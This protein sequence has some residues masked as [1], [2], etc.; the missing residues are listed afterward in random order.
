MPALPR[1]SQNPPQN[2]PLYST[3]RQAH[4]SR[5][6][7]LLQRVPDYI[8][9]DAVRIINAALALCWKRGRAPEHAAE[10]A[11]QPRPA[12]RWRQYAVSSRQVVC[13]VEIA[14]EPGVQIDGLAQSVDLRLRR[15][16]IP[17]SI[18]ASAWCMDLRV[19]FTE[20]RSMSGR[21]SKQFFSGVAR[22]TQA[23]GKRKEIMRRKKPPEVAPR[24]KE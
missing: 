23:G 8:I 9:S 13:Q 2:S 15:P 19:V 22:C 12:P 21:F 17:P 1:P 16:R 20:S 14:P 10:R 7:V 5:S 6:R 4:N 11:V 18:S 24:S 3:G